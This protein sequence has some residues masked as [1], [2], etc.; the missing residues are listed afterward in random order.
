MRVAE[1]LVLPIGRNR[2]RGLVQLPHRDKNLSG[3]AIDDVTIGVHRID[4]V[5]GADLLKV[6]IRAFQY[7]RI[8]QSDV[9]DRQLIR[10][11]ILERERAVCGERPHF[12]GVQTESGSGR[13]HVVADELSLSRKFVR[14]DREALNDRR[15]YKSSG[16]GHERPRTDR[17]E[18]QSPV[19]S[20]DIPQEKHRGQQGDDG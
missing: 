20:S 18:S 1:D 16:D 2:R 11:N 13:F 9:V 10:L 7:P 6:L 8:P 3:L 12:D 19:G 17:H 15:V 4:P 14:L 5:I